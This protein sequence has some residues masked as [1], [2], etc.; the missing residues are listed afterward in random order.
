VDDK[1]AKVEQHPLGRV[2]AFA[3]PWTNPALAKLFFDFVAD[4]LHVRCAEAGAQQEAIGESVDS[5]V[6]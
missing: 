6:E 1:T 3:V 5:Q 4:G 2:V